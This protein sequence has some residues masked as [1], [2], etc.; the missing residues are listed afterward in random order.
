LENG[1]DVSQRILSSAKR[2]FIAKG[3]A[4]TPL[5]AIANEAGTSESG[6]LRIYNSKNGVLRAVYASCWTE[7]NERIEQAMEL[8][9]REDADPRG[10][11]LQLMRAVLEGYLADPPMNTFMLS[12]FGFRDTMGLSHDDEVGPDVDTAVKQGYHIYL[13]RIRTL[14][15]R[16]AETWPALGRAG[17]TGFAL[18]EVFISV[19]YGIQTSWFMADEEQDSSQRCLNVDEAV[20]VMRFV[21]YPELHA[22]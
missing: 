3:F 22:A 5:R 1:T 16:V 9:A 17:V 12:H 21:L 4:K 14:C 6:V 8:A 15:D 20:A 2:L 18:G 11:L 7:I 10:L 13:D 19:T